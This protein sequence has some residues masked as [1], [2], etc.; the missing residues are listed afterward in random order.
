MGFTA[1]LDADQLADAARQVVTLRKSG[2]KQPEILAALVATFGIS[3]STA[4]RLF[5]RDD[6]EA[7][8]LAA[9]DRELDV[10]HEASE[11][12]AAEIELSRVAARAPER[13]EQAP[14]TG[15]IL[16]PA[17]I[18]PEVPPG[19]EK[20]DPRSARERATGLDDAAFERAQRDAFAQEDSR[21]AG[22]KL[23]EAEL[24]ITSQ[25]SASAPRAARG[26]FR[27]IAQN[28]E[29]AVRAG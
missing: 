3:E 21:R 1:K 19:W 22:Y 2:H 27:S 24:D 9:A 5:R 16:A 18:E 10:L 6:F 15:R 7:L 14:E 13:R 28:L 17:R 8:V 20:T 29:D 25:R 11:R 12:A 26:G 23:G 4:R